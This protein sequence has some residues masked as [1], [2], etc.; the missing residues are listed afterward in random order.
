[1]EVRSR[2]LGRFNGENLSLALAMLLVM[3]VPR[4]SACEV[5]SRIS[6]PPGRMEIFRNRDPEGP[7]VVID[8]AHTPDALA[9]ALEAVRAH[10]RGRVIVV[11]GCGGDRDPGKRAEMGRVAEAG[12]DTVIVTDDNPRS[13]DG[14]RI[15]ADILEGMRGEPRVIRERETAIATAVQE[16]GPGDI[17]LV[18]GKGHEDYQLVG[19]QRL[20]FSDRAV[21]ARLTGGA[22]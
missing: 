3:E 21:A 10:C 4:E 8:Y 22:A 19:A 16:A 7:V 15:V 18:A 14:G 6:A 9:K 1:M 17:V 5:L 13:E 2:L 11:F 20:H 12:A